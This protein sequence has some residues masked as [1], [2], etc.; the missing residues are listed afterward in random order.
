MAR[1]VRDAKLDSRTARA[2]L[3]PS[4]IPYYKGIDPGLHLGY[5]K[6]KTGGRWVLRWRTPDDRYQVETIGTADD[7]ADPDGVAILSFAEAQAAARDR[8]AAL[9]RAAKGLPAV[10]GPYTVRRCLE[11]YL[12]YLEAERKS[13]Q[14]ARWR[15]ES[16]I[17]PTLGDVPCADLTAGQIKAWRDAAVKT[18]PRLRT[19]KGAA[20][21]YRKIDPDDEDARRRRCVATNRNLLLLKAA[22]NKAWK[23]EKIVGDPWRR[24]D[25]F[26]DV[27]VARMHYLSI[28]EC[29]RLI[30][31][32][33]G[34]FRDLVRV[35]LATGARYG[36]LARFEVR[37]FNRD[38]GTLQIQI[39]KTG[40]PRHVVLND[41]GMALLG[42]LTAG[43]PGSMRLLSKADGGR[44]GKGA[45]HRPMVE[46]CRR[47]G[48]EPPVGFHALRHTYA[49][50]AIMAGAPQRVVA[51]NLGHADT[52]MVEKHYGHLSK[53]YI[54]TE[55]RRAAPRFGIADDGV[56]AAIR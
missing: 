53:G 56:I 54:E 36:E 35:A 33:E 48:I 39:S 17:L 47:G 18:P 25:A 6:G 52:R 38:V 15:I 42:R 27:D 44:W 2:K 49:S 32:A 55:I 28:D 16:I 5:R 7:I 3:K 12:A 45:Q 29:R 31:A 24:V 22:L 37:D 21:R 9:A 4:G 23:D 41:E 11:E 46:A 13:A 19:A 40:K 50:L 1:T 43:R 26:K 14:D 30:N 8:R 20:P 10:E 51:E 34:E